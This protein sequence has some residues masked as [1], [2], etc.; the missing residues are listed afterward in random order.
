[1][2]LPVDL[3]ALDDRLVPRAAAGLRKVL[4]GAAE[5]RAS[6]GSQTAGPLRRLDDR[7]ASRGPLRL[8]RDVPQL[9]LLLAALLF[10]GGAGVALSQR[11]GPTTGAQQT[12]AGAGS[13]AQPGLV[14]GPPVGADAEAHLE[15]AAERLAGLAEQD[16]DA[17]HLALVSLRSALTPAQTGALLERAGVDL[18]RAYLRADVP[19][20]PE[21]VLF[22]TPGDVVSGLQQV[23]AATATRKAD[24]QR[25]L[26]TTAATIEGG[27]EL[28]QEFLALYEQ[29]ASTAGAEAAAYRAGCSCV[30]ALV[31][32]G[33]TAELQALLEL[34]EVRGVE[35]ASRGAAVASLSVRPLRPDETG[36]VSGDGS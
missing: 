12:V 23:F 7:F 33:E 17:R 22:Q 2:K 14:L 10:L 9:G 29:D 13:A 26:L 31:V 20:R 11:E 24:E 30:F 16:P 3:R 6:L 32:A 18:E 25:D 34:P 27:T 28:E 4:D 1:M 5:R 21:Q 35:P 19:G 15:Q 8:L 36:T